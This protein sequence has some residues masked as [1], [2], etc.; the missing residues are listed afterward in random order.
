[1]STST[2]IAAKSEVLKSIA[3]TGERLAALELQATSAASPTAT[4]ALRGG[5]N[6]LRSAVSSLAAK[7]RYLDQCAN[8]SGVD[9][10]RAAI[11]RGDGEAL[12]K[13][14][15]EEVFE[16]VSPEESDPSP[17]FL[18]EDIWPLWCREHGVTSDV[19]TPELP[20][21]G[22]WV[23]VRDRWL[24]VVR[25][26]LAQLAAE[27]AIDIEDTRRQD[28]KLRRLAEHQIGGQPGLVTDESGG[29]WGF[30]PAR[31]AETLRLD[32]ALLRNALARSRS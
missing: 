22:S 1:M 7:V 9:P 14:L 12:L 11:L 24:P 26:S 18:F 5:C 28:A 25:K 10:V 31:T 3:A 6:E 8:R 29:L 2:Y 30:D 32:E 4:R 20:D 16:V 21:G 19:P 27:L 13:P 23:R 15:Y 17:L